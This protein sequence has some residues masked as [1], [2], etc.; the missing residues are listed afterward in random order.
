MFYLSFQYG[1]LFGPIDN[2]RFPV[3]FDLMLVLHP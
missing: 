1:V 2:R 3:L